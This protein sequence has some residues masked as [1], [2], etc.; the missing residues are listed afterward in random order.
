MK[1][2]RLTVALLAV[3]LTV[4]PAYAQ[5]GGGVQAQIPFSFA[6]SGKTFPAGTYTMIAAS[7]RLKIEDGITSGKEAIVGLDKWL[8][9]WVEYA[10]D[11]VEL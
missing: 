6:V 2:S 8:S 7:H 11:R 1:N 10:Y 9:V 3:G 5:R 4:I